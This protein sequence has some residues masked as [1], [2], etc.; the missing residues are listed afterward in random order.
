[1]NLT[2]LNMTNFFMFFHHLMAPQRETFD[3]VL[4]SRINNVVHLN[5]GFKLFLNKSFCKKWMLKFNTNHENSLNWFWLKIIWTPS[6]TWSQYV[7]YS[8]FELHCTKLE[9]KSKRIRYWC[10]IKLSESSF[11]IRAA[12]IKSST[13]MVPIQWQLGYSPRLTS[14]PKLWFWKEDVLWT[15]KRKVS[16]YKS[17]CMVWKAATITM[18]SRFILRSLR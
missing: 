10:P 11:R 8:V 6:K 2:E 15:S 13:G 4:F 16:K 5:Y 1:M 12:N 9:C 17:K 18:A 14:G 7:G 3:W